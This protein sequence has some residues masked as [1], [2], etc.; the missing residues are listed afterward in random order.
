MASHA[1][2]FM[3]RGLSTKWKRTVGYFL[4]AG[5]LTCNTLQSLTRSCIDKL[6]KM[7]LSVEVLICDQGSNNRQLHDSFEKVTCDRPFITVNHNPVFVIYYLPHL[8][9][10]IRNNSE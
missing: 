5:P 7:G 1:L 8:L 10:N 6:T 3:V 4:S 2:A 9:K